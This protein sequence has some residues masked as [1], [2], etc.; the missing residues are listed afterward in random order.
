MTLPAI[1]TMLPTPVHDENRQY[2]IQEVEKDSLPCHIP[3]LRRGTKSDIVMVTTLHTSF[4]ERC[5]MLICEECSS[6]CHS[7]ASK[8]RNCT[9]G[10][11]LSHVSRE[12][13]EETTKGEDD[14]REYKASFPAEDVAEFSV[15]RPEFKCFSYGIRR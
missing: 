6:R 4:V 13:T 1:Q 5:A 12:T 11:Q 14:I 2:A 7:S 3:L 9:G 10:N 15:K 8:A